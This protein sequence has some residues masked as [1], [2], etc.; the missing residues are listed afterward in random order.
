MRVWACAKDNG[1][2]VLARRPSICCR[3]IGARSALVEMESDIRAEGRALPCRGYEPPE[4]NGAQAE[5]VRK[6]FDAARITATWWRKSRGQ[7]RAAAA[8]LTP[9]TDTGGSACAAPSRSLRKAISSRTREAQAED[10]LGPA[11]ETKGGGAV[12]GRR[13]PSIPKTHPAPR[14]CEFQNRT[15]ATAQQPWSTGSPSARR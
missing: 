2:G 4:K 9:G 5:Q 10:A 3:R 7:G 6:L 12:F 15:W 14:S 8:R 1:C 13:A 11:L